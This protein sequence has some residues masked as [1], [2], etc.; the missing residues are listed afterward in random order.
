MIKKIL[1]ALAAVGAFVSAMFFMLLKQA[2]TEK[3]FKEVE[4]KLKESERREEQTDA[5]RKAENAVHKSKIPKQQ[6]KLHIS[7]S[8]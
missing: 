7:H 3:K 1:A 8:R 4:N 6:A 5:M 2:K